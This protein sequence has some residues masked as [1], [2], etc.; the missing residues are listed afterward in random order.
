M[1]QKKNAWKMAKNGRW[2][3]K[4]KK[5]IHTEKKNRKI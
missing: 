5:E 4:I 2:K 1:K 3:L